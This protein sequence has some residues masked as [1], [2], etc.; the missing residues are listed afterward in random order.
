MSAAICTLLLCCRFFLADRA[1]L[2][3]YSKSSWAVV[4]IRCSLSVFVAAVSWECSCRFGFGL[5][6]ALG[7]GIDVGV[8]AIPSGSGRRVARAPLLDFR[9]RRGGDVAE[10]LELV[11][12]ELDF[13]VVIELV[14][15]ACFPGTNLLQQHSR[16]KLPARAKAGAFHFG[17]WVPPVR[18]L[19]HR[20]PSWCGPGAAAHN[21]DV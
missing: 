16:D 17:H 10:W 4:S 20:R 15:A 18:D 8:F 2:C 11:R 14:D 13:V 6:L 1:L 3:P 9:P 5:A 19:G 12:R 21:E 7:A